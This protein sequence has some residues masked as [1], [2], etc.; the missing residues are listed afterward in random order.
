MPHRLAPVG[1]S[2]LF[3]I[4]PGQGANK[5][6]QYRVQGCD[7]ANNDPVRLAVVDN[8]GSAR[9][10]KHANQCEQHHSQAE[11]VGNSPGHSK[12]VYR[13]RDENGQVEPEADDAMVGK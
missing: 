7:E 8:G 12:A 3:A 9:N 10:E 6:R 13:R 1:Q 4:F 11:L 2:L 5:C